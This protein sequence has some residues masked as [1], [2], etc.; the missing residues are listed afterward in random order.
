MSGKTPMLLLWISAIVGWVQAGQMVAI[1]WSSVVNGTKPAVVVIETERGLGSGF[2]V[3]SNVVL[4]T[5]QHVVA[6]ASQICV[7]FSSGEKYQKAYV[8][9]EDE[10]RDLAILRIEGSDLPFLSLASV[11]DLSI[12]QQVLLI[13]APEGLSQTVSAGLVSAI[14]LLE[15]GTKVIQTTAPASPGNSGGPLLT[16]EG[17]VIG[18]LTFQFSEGQNLNFAVASNYVQAM[19]DTVEK[20]SAGTPLRTLTKLEAR[21]AP[22]SV[23]G[24]AESAQQ[25]IS[26]VLFVACRTDRHRQY[27]SREVFQDIV[28]EVLLFLKQK[29]LRLAND[30]LG[31]TL[32]VDGTISTY[33]VIASAKKAGASHVMVLTV[34]RPWSAWVKLRLQCLTVYGSILWEEEAKNGSWTKT[35][36][37]G[38]RAAMEKFKTRISKDLSQMPLPMIDAP[39][40]EE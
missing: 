18:V 2:V 40:T 14:R 26:G 32:Q 5:N 6:G 21:S 16:R 23:P 20:F 3:R 34:D 15:S 9:A 33:E 31:R 10:G 36:T 1:D 29:K 13:G 17:R 12:G 19:M 8:L 38:V 24:P 35:G 30:E 7:T 4:V 27:S 39:P 28:D 22:R 37:G 11:A 25:K